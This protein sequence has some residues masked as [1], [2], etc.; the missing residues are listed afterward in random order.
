VLDESAGRDERA[1]ALRALAR[2][3]SSS[4]TEAILRAT[5]I[6]DIGLQA[7]AALKL[8]ERDLPAHRAYVTELA[9]T[10]PEDA[11]YRAQEVI[12]YLSSPDSE[13]HL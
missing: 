10:W 11:P 3:E 7:S 2:S 5:K 13:E 6:R 4:A 8:L 1:A 12:E 9:R